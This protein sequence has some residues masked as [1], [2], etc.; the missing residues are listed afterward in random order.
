MKAAP[1]HKA[2]STRSGVKHVLMDFG[3]LDKLYAHDTYTQLELPDPVIRYEEPAKSTPRATFAELVRQ[4]AEG[5]GRLK[6]DH[7]LLYGDIDVSVAAAVAAAASGVPYTHVEA[8]LRSHDFKDHEESNRL[9]L[10]RLASFFVTHAVEAVE[11][12]RS[13]V[14]AGGDD[15]LLTASPAIETLLTHVDGATDR[16]LDALGLEPSLY[17]LATIH[18]RE[19]LRDQERFREIMEGLI[20]VANSLRVVLL[21]YRST[22]EVVDA[23]FSG[24]EH[25]VL[26]APTMSY[27][28]YVGLL[29]GARI[30]ITDSSGLQDEAAALGIP[31]VTCRTTTH[32]PKASGLNRL[33]GHSAVQIEAIAAELIS[34]PSDFLPDLPSLWRRPSGSD[35]GEFLQA[36]LGF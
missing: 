12:L 9:L 14:Q 10:D 34:H 6:P 26:L 29:K 20:G 5:I 13:E 8:G 7:L 16:A 3:Y 17:C 30:I 28:D 35:I 11:T 24:I 25:Q 4:I 19:T 32:R 18:R 1:I 33:A 23:T 22:R 15:V 21:T 31:S 2:L 27:L 36:R